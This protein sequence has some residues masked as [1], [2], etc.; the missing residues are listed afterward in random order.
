MQKPC[1]GNHTNPTNGY[2]CSTCS[3]A[4]VCKRQLQV[5]ITQKCLV[6]EPTVRA[7]VDLTPTP[8]K[9]PPAT[10]AKIEAIFNEYADEESIILPVDAGVWYDYTLPNDVIDVFIERILEIITDATN[11]EV[12]C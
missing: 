4:A 9:L 7:V 3:D 8:F 6:R 12:R 5:K 1:I 2:N 11:L 10:L